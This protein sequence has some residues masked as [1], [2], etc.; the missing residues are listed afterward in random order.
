MD[1]IAP[2]KSLPQTKNRGQR[3]TVT[4]SGS[5][6]LMKRRMAQGRIADLERF[7][8]AAQDAASRAAA[9]THRLLAFVRRQTLDPKLISP[10]LLIANLQDLLQRTVGPTIELETVC[11]ADLGSHCAIPTSWIMRSSTCA[12]MLATPCQMAAGSR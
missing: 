10:N 1:K 11:A 5:L 6:E 4:I 2:A 12:S 3:L 9:L 7:M 8:T